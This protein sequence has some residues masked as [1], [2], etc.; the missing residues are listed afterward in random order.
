MKRR[1]LMTL[2]LLVLF[3]AF[4]FW[5]TTEAQVN[6]TSSRSVPNVAILIWNGVQIIDY[7]GPYEVLGRRNNVYTV[8][9]TAEPITTNMG[10][11]VT[12]NYSFGNQPKPDVLIIPG[13]GIWAE[14]GPLNNPRIIKWIQDNAKD[15]Q[16]VLSVCGGALLLA[17]AGLLDG[18]EATTTAGGNIE[19]LKEFAPKA[20]VVTDKRFVDN[21]KIITSAGL[22][23]GIDGALHLV[24][25]M[26]GEGWAERIAQAMEYNSQ[27]QSNYARANL[28]DLRLP[29]AIR[30]QFDREAEPVSF[31][32]DSDSWEEKWLVTSV[33]ANQ[34]LEKIN[35]QWAAD[36][37]WSKQKLLNA[38]NS[39][40]TLWQ[41]T[42]E[43]N[44]TWSALARVETTGEP[45]KQVV[46]LRIWRGEEMRIGLNEKD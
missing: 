26:D 15:A 14:K 39:I 18:L 45:G 40:S 27:P 38:T 11:R 30:G 43:K 31:R 2:I 22:S 7:T 8:A 44:Q 10:M 41:S 20:K 35:K 16:H 9:E 19:K 13:G 46:I 17:K 32:G 25:V 37:K 29:S 4:E 24:S 3:I 28:P 42:D 23:A 5:T 12:P 33:S 6:Q 36:S 1:L 21:G 34:T